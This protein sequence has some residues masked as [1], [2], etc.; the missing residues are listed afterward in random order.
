MRYLRVV[1]HGLPS[2]AVYEDAAVFWT[3]NI[4]IFGIPGPS[5]PPARAYSRAVSGGQTL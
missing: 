4:S 1:A 3:L 5:L 2:R